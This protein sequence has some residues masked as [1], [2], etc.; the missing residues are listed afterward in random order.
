MTH[1]RTLLRQDVWAAIDAAPELAAFK[2]LRAEAFDR[3]TSVLPSVAVA[4]PREA[5]RND[6][7]GT[8]QR[9]VDIEVT[10]RK[11][12]S[13]TVEDELDSLSS[14][15]ERIVMTALGAR[16]DYHALTTTEMFIDGR[17]DKRI[18]NMRMTFRALAMTPEANPEI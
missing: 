7:V 17:G 1:I 13:D 14:V 11:E 8:V 4:T 18:G 16:A 9:H 5:I 12:G 6:A 3:D 10:V 15:V 2:K